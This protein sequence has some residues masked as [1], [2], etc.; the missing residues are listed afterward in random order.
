MNPSF[1]Y[2]S[3][4]DQPANI[5]RLSEV[6]VNV[7]SKTDSMG[8]YIHLLQVQAH[9]AGIRWLGLHIEDLLHQP[10]PLNTILLHMTDGIYLC[11]GNYRLANSWTES[12]VLPSTASP[13]L[14]LKTS[15]RS[16]TF[17]DLMKLKNVS[18]CVDDALNTRI[19]IVSS[20]N[21]LLDNHRADRQV[22]DIV[23]LTNPRGSHRYRCIGFYYKEA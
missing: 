2:F 12:P 13:S 1:Q 10:L 6:V 8:E 3:M 21:Q 11:P 20:I 5:K 16:E 15:E 17:D 7:W 18:A 23:G 4:A 19:G 14:Q 9:L 22:I